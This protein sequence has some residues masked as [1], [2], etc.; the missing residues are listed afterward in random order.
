MERDASVS[1]LPPI[2]WETT[3]FVGFLG[4]GLAGAAALLGLIAAATGDPPTIL[5]TLRLAL[6]FAGPV[7][8]G[9]AVSFRPDLW[10]TWLIGA[11]TAL[12]AVFGTPNHWDSFKILFAVLT[13]LA[14]LRGLFAV[15]STPARRAVVSAFILIH[16]F[17]ILMATTSP[18]PT[19]W[20]VDQLYR[21]IYEPY[22]QFSYMRNAYHFYSPEPG[23][24]SLM[25][26][27]LKTERGD[28]VG[29]D[30]VIRKKYDLQWYILPRRTGDANH[31]SDIKDPLGVTY[32]RRLSL[33]DQIARGYPDLMNSETFEK[34]EIR[35]RRLRLTFAGN[36]PYIPMHPTEPDNLEYRLPDA[37]ATRY[38]L[39]SYAQHILM[40]LPAE[41]QL[42]TTVKIYRVEHRTLGPMEFIGVVNEGKK[43]GDP[44]HPVTY[45]PYFLGE[46]GFRPDGTGSTRVEL[47]N[48]EEPMLYWLLPILPKVNNT[49]SSDPN[50]KDYDD[51]MS[52]H[53][54]REF[55][56]S[57]LK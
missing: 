37:L 15:I 29:A 45:R 46:F 8:A 1:V 55:D 11:G 22:L 39:P 26:C 43:P 12:L 20:M 24:A 17:G 38:L 28:E 16:F 4:L 18:G 52:V 9:L 5:Q 51:Y 34:S 27:L 25:V 2:E 13:A 31:A 32:F 10:Q 36:D 47:L 42:R 41:D 21:R 40:D 53:A 30:G 23:P 49:A 6:I 19:P 57:L 54:G 33:T 7:L 56:W 44:Y 3:R 14:L 35:A 50:K 48:P